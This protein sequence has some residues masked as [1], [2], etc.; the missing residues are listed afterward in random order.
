MKMLT[1]VVGFFLLIFSFAYYQAS[2]LQKGRHHRGHGPSKHYYNGPRPHYRP[3][4]Y[5]YH[6]PARH[7]YKPNHYY[8]PVRPHRYSQ[9]RKYRRHYASP[10]P[11]VVVRL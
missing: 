6:R 8:R 7:Y 11:V 2:P 9:H 10:R 4:A 5:R 3:V 1:K